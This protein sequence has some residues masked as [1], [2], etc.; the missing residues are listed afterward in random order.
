MFFFEWNEVHSSPLI[1]HENAFYRVKKG[2]LFEV[3]YRARTRNGNLRTLKE[4]NLLLEESV[5]LGQE[6][7]PYH[8]MSKIYAKE[9]GSLV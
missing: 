3:L 7:G 4:R 2:D 6:W 1:K 8:Q 9:L 5:N